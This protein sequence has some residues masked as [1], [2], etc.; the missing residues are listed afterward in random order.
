[1]D[2]L[3]GRFC[4]GGGYVGHGAGLL[5]C[6]EDDGCIYSGNKRCVARKGVCVLRC[7]VL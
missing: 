7:L 5:S 2:G 3:C 4:G 6:G 1:M